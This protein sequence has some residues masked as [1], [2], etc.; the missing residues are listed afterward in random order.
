MEGIDSEIEALV[1]KVRYYAE[2]VDA[3]VA[4]RRNDFR[5]MCFWNIHK[6][7]II[8]HEIVGFYHASWNRMGVSQE[9]KAEMSERMVTITKNMFTDIVSS[10]EKAVKD[11]V[12][13]YPQSGLKERSLEGGRNY[14]YLRNIVNDSADLGYI[15][16]TSYHEWDTILMMRNLV[17]HNNS[18]SDRRGVF[19]A[20]GI[21]IVMRPN[22]M[23]KG[24]SDTFIRLS[25]RMV[26]LFHEWLMSVHRR[27]SS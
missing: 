16:M 26:E 23:M 10:I 18:A 21:H 4:D 2:Q 11:C 12:D 17:T 5:S 7:A 24:P 14:L 15:P 8:A 20:C 13:A 6:R 25:A 19:D 9:L 27:F 1:G 3:E 22:R